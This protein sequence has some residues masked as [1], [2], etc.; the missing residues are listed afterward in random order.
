MDRIK[1]NLAVLAGVKPFAPKVGDMVEFDSDRQTEKGPSS[2]P[3]TKVADG[4]VT[5]KHSDHPGETFTIAKVKVKS[6]NPSA[7]DGKR[8]WILATLKV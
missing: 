5:V 6:F 8:L 7:S 1:A 4:K 3:V 2:G